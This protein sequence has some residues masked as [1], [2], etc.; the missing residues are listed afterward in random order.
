MVEKRYYVICGIASPQKYY[1]PDIKKKLRHHLSVQYRFE[2]ESWWQL[3][4]TL[5]MQVQQY[6]HPCPLVADAEQ[7]LCDV[8]MEMSSVLA[9]R[10]LATFTW[11]PWNRIWLE[12]I[13]FIFPEKKKHT[14]PL[15][16]KIQV[17]SSI[18][19]VFSGP[20]ISVRDS[21]VLR[22]AHCV[23]FRSKPK[24]NKFCK[25]RLPLPVP[26]SC[27]IHIQ[28]VHSGTGNWTFSWV[29]S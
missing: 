15:Q 1:N 21:T 13:F 9:A 19:T 20:D 22:L 8:D 11:D 10:E 26:S 27:R 3:S 24:W 5:D 28:T 6:K 4:Q 29:P 14:L 25:M 18:C 16:W 2:Q 17:A 12:K 7:H 23:A